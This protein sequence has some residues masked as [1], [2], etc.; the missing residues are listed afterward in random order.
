MPGAAPSAIARPRA[1]HAADP[2]ALVRAQ[3]TAALAA[4]LKR[5]WADAPPGERRA[6]FDEVNAAAEGG[7]PAAR[8]VGLEILEARS[9]GRRL[10]GAPPG[11]RQPARRA[12]RTRGGCELTCRRM[13]AERA[14]YCGAAARRACRQY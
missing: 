9:L 2:V 8:R 11:R 6:F 12:G 13:R 1:R 5:G 3:L 10:R 14:E 7:G 4:L